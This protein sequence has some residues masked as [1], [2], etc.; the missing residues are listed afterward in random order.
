MR[1]LILIAAAV[2]LTLLFRNLL[3][4]SRPHSKTRDNSA[5]A[6]EKMVACAKCRLYLPESEALPAD[7]SFFCNREHHSAWLEDKRARA[8]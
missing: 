8:D 5:Q 1:L 6:P 7:G 4:R 3:P 2:L